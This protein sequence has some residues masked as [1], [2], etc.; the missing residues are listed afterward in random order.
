MK[1]MKWLKRTILSAVIISLCFDLIPFFKAVNSF[2]KTETGIVE[3]D[4]EDGCIC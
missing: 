3:S 2:A 4:F 1:K